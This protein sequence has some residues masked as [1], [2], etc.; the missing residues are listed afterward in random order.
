MTDVIAAV[1]AGGITDI[2]V[3]NN[4]EREDLRAYGRYAAI[5]EAKHDLIYVQDDDELV[6]DI[7]A[8]VQAWRPGVVVVNEG[9]PGSR[10]VPWVG[11]GA[12][13]HR[14]APS[15]FH[16]RYL[17]RWPRDELFLDFC[18]PVF[19]LQADTVWAHARFEE[20][21]W[22]YASNRTSIQ[23]GY[24]EQRRP[25]VLQRIRAL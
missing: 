3:W 18:D 1:A 10:D 25:E 2:V 4:A 7:P 9:H 12:V 20:L 23:P 19:T 8:L 24:W 13:F 17:E 14:D 15:P 5:A 21:P 11:W 16:D 22:T 6:R